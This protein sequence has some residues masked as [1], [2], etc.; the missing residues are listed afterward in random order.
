M[1]I[2]Q[3][4][5]EPILDIA[6][7]GFG[8]SNLAL[9]IALIEEG[10]QPGSLVFFEQQPEFRWH[11]GMLAEDTTM[12]ISFLKDLVTMRNPNSDFS[13]VSYLHSQSRL[14]D[15][16]NS[17]TFYPL[18]VEFHDY[19]EWAAERVADV[20]TYGSSVER[21]VPVTADGAVGSVELT[22]RQGGMTRAY[23]ARNVVIGTGLVPRLPDGV[24]ASERVWHSETMIGGAEAL[25]AA[26]SARIA[27]LG[28]GQSAAEATAYLHRRF[29][30]A[31]I[32][33]VFSRYGYSAADDTP[34][35]NR[36]F[37][38]EAVDHFFSAPESVKKQLLGYH[39]NTNY[40]VVDS[41]LITELYQRQ[42]QERV[43][44]RERLHV[45][46]T[47]R[48]LELTE[49]ADGVRLRVEFLPTGT[50]RTLDVDAVICATGYEPE[51]PE[52]VLGTLAQDCK[53]DN[54][55]RLVLDRD[56]RVLTSNTVHC[57]IYVHGPAAE[58]SHGIGAGLL[59]NTAVRAAE[60]SRSLLTRD[61]RR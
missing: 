43:R 10:A 48:L 31:E 21:I 17:K 45:L 29:P 26:A 59:S 49:S 39:A 7:C 40:S 27:V 19:L 2:P 16:I 42:Y 15:F 47:S 50:V 22:V 4:S 36:I 1:S 18:R 34:F 46:S 58:R 24:T 23:H 56:Y 11:S 14:P 53:R 38:P 13:F 5:G 52:T 8:P 33:A 57:G 3:S 12:Q 9:A 25:A 35:A 60:M 32:Y 44:G 20:V 51:D 61:G 28:A 55:G 41:E 6:G 37:D 30:T 54:E